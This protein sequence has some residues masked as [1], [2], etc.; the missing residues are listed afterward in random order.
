[1]N[2]IPPCPRLAV[3]VPCHN[4]ESTIA[5]VVHSFRRTLAS[6]VIYVYDNNSSDQTGA[7]AREAGAV[8][9][10]EPHQGKGN[11]M[12]RMFAD[13]EADIYVLVDG[14][15]TYDAASAPAL[16][17]R[18][19]EDGLDMVVGS[20]LESAGDEAFRRGHRFG[21]DL[22]TGFVGLLFGRSFTDMLSGYRVF[23]R[24]FVKS[25]PALARGFETETELTVHALELRM[26]I[27]EIMT[28]YKTRPSGSQSKL[29][30]YRDGARIM[31]TILTLFKEER[32]LTFFSMLGAG[33]AGA[34][35][36]IAYPVV[37]TYMRTGL[38]P[39]FP[40]AILATG[41][42]IMAF[43][44]LAAGFILATVTHG[45]REM[46]RLFYLGIPALDR[47]KRD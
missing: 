43:L 4:E 44:S 9:R 46:K 29:R 47:Y 35:L 41:I 3:L 32:P 17:A 28:P 33:L 40:T 22:L 34:A 42:M 19:L 20:R 24:R 18:L 23:S 37:V 13:I 15:D 5:A 39:R 16:I 1:M 8:V 14:D 7:R 10:G 27:A 25:F 30:T 21:N 2:M 31:M 12:R 38:V 45:R 6:A 26:P 36:V 11:V